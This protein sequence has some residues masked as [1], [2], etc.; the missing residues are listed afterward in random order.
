MLEELTFLWPLF[1]SR[2]GTFAK[3]IYS[4]KAPDLVY[5]TSPLLLL[6]P[7]VT[8]SWLLL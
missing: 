5:V 1:R 8:E 4:T 6:F 2:K 3:M 7:K